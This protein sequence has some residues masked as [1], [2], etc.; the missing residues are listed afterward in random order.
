MRFDYHRF[1]SFAE[2]NELTLLCATAKRSE[3]GVC[4]RSFVGFG[5]IIFFVYFTW[6]CCGISNFGQLHVDM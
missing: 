2:I 4:M 1:I 6:F 5:S 3:S